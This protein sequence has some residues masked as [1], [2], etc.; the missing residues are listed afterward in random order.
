MC[1]TTEVKQK[2]RNVGVNRKEERLGGEG[3]GGG[4]EVER[5]RERKKRNYSKAFR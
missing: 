2:P 5:E 1:C 4:A 3:K